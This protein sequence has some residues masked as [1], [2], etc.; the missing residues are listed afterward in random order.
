MNVR[1]LLRGV[2][3]LLAAALIVAGMFQPLEAEAYWLLALWAAAPLFGAAAWLAVPPTAPSL[4]RNVANVGLVILVGFGLLSLQLLRQQ[5]LRADEIYYHVAI[6]ADGSTTSNVR[7]VLNSQ[8]I[9]RGRMFDRKGTLLADSQSVAGFAQRTYPIAERYDPALFGHVL[10]FFSTRYGQS[11]LESFYNSY[12]TGE[13]GNELERLRERL[14]GGTPRGND[15]TLTLNAD[16]Q[17]AAAGA[18]GGRAGS[19]VVL[20]PRTGAILA[21]VSQ[22]SFDPRGLTFNPAA[23]SWD[24]ENLRVGQYWEQLIADGAQ[25]PLINR[26]TQGLYPPG[27]TFKSLT[28]IAVLEHAAVGQPE[29]ISCPETYTPQPGAPPIVNA[30][31][32]LAGLTGEP[33]SLERV[34]AYSCN[35]AFAQYAIRLGPEIFTEVARRFDILPPQRGNTNYDGFRELPT[36]QSLLY[37]EPGFLNMP[38]A[39]ADTGYG[40]GQLLVT[41]LQMAMLTAAI[42]NEGVMMQPYVVQRV[43]RPDGGQITSHVPRTIR[44][45]MEAQTARTMLQHMAAVAQYGFGSNVDNFT[46]PG[47][48]VGGKSGTAEH[49][50]GARPHAWFIAVAPLDTP[51]FAVAVMV[52]SGG[53]GSSVGA[54]LAGRVLGAAFATE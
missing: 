3:L 6:A 50:P 15:L 46:P 18:L 10:G 20:D 8:R 40:Q 48:A 37:V 19:V 38:R 51:R 21:L 23:A 30:V 24:A 32:N 49:V 27:S 2:A 5:V 26:A 44:R 52:E 34:F 22:P 54:E 35:T 25:Q 17:A 12:L 11:G 7:P 14:V 13:R 1:A 9:L 47:V 45:T 29:T 53:E 42:A 4:A 28:A 43:T 36:A 41:P 31:P 16:L 33:A 39:L